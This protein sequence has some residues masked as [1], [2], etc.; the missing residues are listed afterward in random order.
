VGYLPQRHAEAAEEEAAR[1]AD[2]DARY[3]AIRLPNPGWNEV[4]VHNFDLD[5]QHGIAVAS[6]AATALPSTQMSMNG[7]RMSTSRGWSPTI[8]GSACRAPAPSR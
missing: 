1:L 7:L 4:Q 3:T 8:I 5:Q 6:P 2:R